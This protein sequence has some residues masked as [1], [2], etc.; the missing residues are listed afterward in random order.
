MRII[1]VSNIEKF[2]Q[3]ILPKQPQKNKIIVESILKNVNRKTLMHLNF[4]NHTKQNDNT[5]SPETIQ[6]K[7]IGMLELKNST[8]PYIKNSCFV[9]N[10]V[11]GLFI[12]T[13]TDWFA[14][15]L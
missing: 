8:K 6:V 5:F 14:F 10:L 7:N 4:I 13:K 11:S 12:K 15:D 1:K 9:R 3:K 2:T